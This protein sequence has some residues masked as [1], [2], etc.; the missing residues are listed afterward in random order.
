MPHALVD[1]TDRQRFEMQ[2]DGGMAFVA[3]RRTPEAL[4]LLH[5]EVPAALAGQGV[6]SALARLTFEHARNRG[7]RVV[8]RCTFLAA[9]LRRH[10]E[11]ADLLAP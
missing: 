8:P 7:I 5:A 9:Y 11:Y 2:L 3:Y 6:G 4:H 1:N 10:P